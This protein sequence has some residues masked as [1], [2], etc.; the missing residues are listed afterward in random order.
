MFF[1]KRRLYFTLF[2]LRNVKLSVLLFLI[3]TK[4]CTFAPVKLIIDIGNTVAKLVAFEGEEPIEEIKTNNETLAALPAFANKY[5]FECGIVGSVIG[6]PNAVEETL[7]SMSF[8]ILRF[9]PDTPIPIC[10]KYKTPHT[11]GSDRLAAAVGAS[12]LKPGKDIL[13]IDAGTCITYDVIDAKKNYW[14][15]NIAPGMQMRLHALHEHTVRL[16][17]VQAEGEVPGLGYNTETAIRS[18]VLRGMKYEIEGYIKSMRAKYPNLL[19]FLTGGDKINF[20]TNIKNSIF[21][22]KFIVPRGLNKILDYNYDK[23]Q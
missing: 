1:R 23:I 18:G 15:G 21:A 6:I 8:P 13:I 19:V 3:S 22:D 20:D 17:L 11:L 14:G 9:T 7:N 5:H 12:I 4:K 16:P 10:N 2:L